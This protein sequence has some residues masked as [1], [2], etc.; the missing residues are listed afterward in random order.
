MT[1]PDNGSPEKKFVF[2]VRDPRD[3][4]ISFYYSFSRSHVIPVT[5]EMRESIQA[6]RKAILLKT[7]DEDAK[8]R[9]I[10]FVLNIIDL[11]HSK[12]PPETT[13]VYRYEDVIFRKEEWLLHSYF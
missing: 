13:R 7:P 11:Y 1:I 3:R 5:G 10:P 2:L 6:Q 9:M 4:L 8:N 12:L